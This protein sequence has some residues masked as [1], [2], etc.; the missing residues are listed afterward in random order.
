MSDES[1]VDL[2]M[3]ENIA[4]DTNGDGDCDE[5]MVPSTGCK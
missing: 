2:I 1:F 5:Y 4:A 3:E